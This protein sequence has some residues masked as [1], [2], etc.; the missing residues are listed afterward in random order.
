MKARTLGFSGMLLA[1]MALSTLTFFAL[2]V[3]A[4]ELQDEFGI[5]KFEIGLLGAVN[6]LVGGL[7]APTAGRLSDQLGGKVSIGLTLGIS[8]TSAA[9]LALAPTYILLLA[10]AAFAGFAQGWGNPACNKAIATGIEAS[11]RGI[12]T[13]IKQSG[14]QAGVFLAGFLVPWMIGVSGWRSSMWLVAVLSL[15]SLLGLPLITE[16][17]SDT[18][19]ANPASDS[20]VAEQGN[21]RLPPFVTQVAIYGFLLGLVGGGLGRF[22][23]LFA[24]EEVGL[25][26]ANAGRV[27]GLQGLVAI[28]CRLASGVALDRGVSARKLLLWMGVGGAGAIALI[29][30]ATEASSLLWI[31]TIIGGM[32]LGSW[33]TAANLS[34]IR[35]PESGRATGRLILGFLIGLTIG[36]PLVG[37]SIDSFNS[38]SPAW[39]ASAV[40]ALLGTAAVWQR[41]EG[42]V[43]L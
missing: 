37:W 33:N 30:A 26:L 29:L 23:P 31:G 12:T 16:L 8:A 36:G 27:F 9:T 7:F 28:P 15:I 4:S 5:T 25:S 38:Y 42:E 13:G 24:E 20:Q 35:Q 34:M 3:A 21:G 40:I 1:T 11:R 14:V 39:I 32:T 22:L 18:V 17:S 41:T 6:T 19:V 10:A 2:A 43:A